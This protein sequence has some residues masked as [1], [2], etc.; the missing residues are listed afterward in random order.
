VDTIKPRELWADGEV[1]P[2]IQ[3]QDNIN[4]TLSV[5]MD[6]LNATTNPV[7]IVDDDSGVDPDLITNIVGQV[8]TKRRGSEVR[9]EAPPPIPDSLFRFYEVLRQLAD[10]ESG[11]HDITQ[12]RK[13]TGITAAQA[14]SEMQDAAQTR[15]RLKER[16]LQN[17]LAQLGRLVVSRILQYYQKPRMVRIT[18][19]EGIPEYF[20]WY[21]EE[22]E[23]GDMVMN[24]RKY[25]YDE[26][27]QRHIPETAW[28]QS[29]PSKGMFDIDV[30]AGTSLPFMKGQRASLAM[31]LKKM[32][33]IDDEALLD[34]LEWPN[35]EQVLKRLQQQKEQAAAAQA[36][37]GPPPA[38]GK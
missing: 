16:N 19:K 5:I 22:N 28:Q 29:P 1:G 11:V 17:S 3:T 34:S 4:K 15:I 2:M 37:G 21:T 18:G 23:S 9:R 20:E 6:C 27:Q 7:W 32:N 36:Q 26:A 24:K 33:V 38:P 31:E 35:K 10:T 14:I 13:P 30:I 25:T 8:I 12:G